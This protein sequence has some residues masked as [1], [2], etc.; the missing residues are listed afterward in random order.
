MGQAGRKRSYISDRSSQDYREEK[1]NDQLQ[2]EVVPR[3]R[4][5][6]CPELILAQSEFKTS[7]ECDFGIID[8][9]RLLMAVE[10]VRQQLIKREVTKFMRGDK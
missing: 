6:D 1:D 9:W 3:C 5:T 4:E 10:D 8:E 2:P 7:S